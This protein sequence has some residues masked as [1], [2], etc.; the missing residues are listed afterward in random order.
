MCVVPEYPGN[1]PPPVTFYVLSFIPYHPPML[2]RVTLIAAAALYAIVIALV[3]WP[4]GVAA[5]AQ[6]DDTPLSDTPEVLKQLPFCGVSMQLQNVDNLAG[7]ERCC[8]EI[9]AQGADTV[10]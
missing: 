1:K 3:V 5:P 4:G 10:M 7:Y 6:A 8:D 9:A 2:N